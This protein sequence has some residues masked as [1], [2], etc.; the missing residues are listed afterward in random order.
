MI[1]GSKDLRDIL[2]F[3][4]CSIEYSE[5]P[6]GYDYLHWKETLAKGLVFWLTKE[7]TI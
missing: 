4:G 7:S 5:F 6:C 1:K 2:I 3:K